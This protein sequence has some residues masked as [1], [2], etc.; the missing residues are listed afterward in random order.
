MAISRIIRIGVLVALCS[1]GLTLS[2]RA[3]GVGAIGGTISDES[4]A[5]LPGATVT[6]SSP[7]VI[8][9]DQSTISDARGAYQFTRLVPGRYSVKGELQGFRTM[10]QEGIN[11]S[12]DNTARADLKLAVGDL[13]ETIT[14]AGASPLLDTTSALNQT[15]MS[16]EVLDTL[17]TPNDIWAIARLSPGITLT[18]Y[19]VGGREMLGQSTAFVH[20]SKDD[21]KSYLVDGMDL[22]SYTSGTS[23]NFYPDSF[24]FQEINY[25]GGQSP[26][27]R[28]VG[29]VV[30]NM[31][32]KTGTNA[33]RGSGM[34]SGT[35]SRLAGNNVTPELRTQLLAGVPA[36]A[37]AA[38]PNIEPGGDIDR[39]FDTAIVWS[40]PIVRDRLW[41]VMGGKLGQ[42]NNYK[43]GS[44]NS[45]GTQLLS[46]NTLINTQGK[47]S[48]AV[49]S[50]SQL[51]YMHL[52]VQKGRYH[53]AGGPTVTEFFDTQASLYNNSRNHFHLARWTHV[54][55]PRMVFDAALSVMT[56]QNNQKPQKEVPA[57]AIGVFDA[58]TRVN[59]VAAANYSVQEGTRTNIVSSLSYVA[60]SH[61]LKFGY[62]MI[63]NDGNGGGNS[64]SGMRAVYR[65]GVPDSV[66]TYNHPT[67]YQ[68]LVNQHALYVQDK[69]RPVS[70]LTL[71]LGLRFETAYG[72]INDVGN[73]DQ[74]CQVETIFI[75][76]RCFAAIKGVPDFKDAVPRLA[77]IYDVFGNGTTALKF[78]ANRYRMITD[79][80]YA[81][82][83]TPIRVTS[84][85]RP[86]TVCG[87]GQTSGCDLNGDK[88]PQFAELGPSTGFNLGSTTRYAED[89][90]RPYSNE[91]G[92]E[93]E[94]QLPGL[95]VVSAGY[96][97]RGH[98]NQLAQTNLAVPREGYTA[99]QV[100]E[101]SSGRQVTV[102]N[103]D[104]ATRGR[105]DVVIDNS[106]ARNASFHGVDMTVQKR[107]NNHWMLLGSLSVGKSEDDIY[108]GNDLN[109]PNFTFR[110]GPTTQDVP[111]FFKMA[112][113]YELPYGVTLGS[114]VQH[115]AGWPDTTTVR[116][117]AD[118][119][120]LTQV[121]QNI[122]VEPRGTTS[123]PDVTMVDLN[124][125]KILT[126][127]RRRFEPRVDFFN[128]LNASAIT[129]RITQLG[130]AYGRAIEI[131]GAR[132][133]KLG[134]NV[135][136]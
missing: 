133:I 38:N 14:V 124:F 95:V 116:V 5:V 117:A 28:S 114:S 57:G 9:G 48:W 85:T 135:N 11:V 70:K 123:L 32:S 36:A 33:V 29:G 56:G 90:T 131:L 4:G 76:G 30:M 17:P 106:P 118:T 12:S 16:R 101:A 40:G 22:N 19:D 73:E 119:V 63:R 97:Y 100:T 59:T 25:E 88:I 46:D 68:I 49:T 87:A 3:Q 39:L 77:A 71:S 84:D 103:Q 96:F 2:A 122:V 42:S 66:N 43:V 92:A 99:L 129:Q 58:V 81:E 55:S 104:P 132:I 79:R 113:A 6:L 60:G 89:I 18:K 82:V 62:Q 74:L 91:I 8:G 45:D 115:F 120:R 51:H 75:A 10:I 50:N 41:F 20:G 134:V 128:L 121:N 23:I 15:V 52:W 1:M 105:F 61:D 37:L 86:W 35:N 78:S 27:E 127:G 111:H 136:W 94:Q 13:A 126:S 24:S 108:A 93:I 53:V 98:R 69:W 54:L 26:A 80:G 130:P 64:P 83:I 47:L 110:R 31:V 65:N 67:K 125:R 44:Y 102:Y 107:M 21:E 112:G 7:G 109:N 34:F 72:R